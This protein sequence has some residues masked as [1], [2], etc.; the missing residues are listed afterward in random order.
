MLDAQQTLLKKEKERK[1]EKRT[2]AHWRRIVPP[3]IKK[4]GTALH[5]SGL[6]WYAR[7]EPCVR[8]FMLSTGLETRPHQ[9]LALHSWEMGDLLLCSATR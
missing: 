7:M 4:D 2:E 8:H 5:W 9:V 6:V 1:E 3:S